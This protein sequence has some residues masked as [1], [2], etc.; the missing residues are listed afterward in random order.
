MQAQR[1]AK[2]FLIV[3]IVACAPVAALAADAPA[4]TEPVK[5]AAADPATASARTPTR[6]SARYRALR[7]QQAMAARSRS[8]SFFACPF[9]HI[10][11]IGY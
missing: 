3:A 8:C 5:T 1:S 6:T 11:G 4:K 7:R 10:L 9:Q 2:A